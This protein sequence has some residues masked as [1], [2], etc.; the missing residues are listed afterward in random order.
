MKSTQDLY[1]IVAVCM[2]HGT[3]HSTIVQKKF[4]MQFL[5]SHVSIKACH[6]SHASMQLY[7][8]KAKQYDY[9][10]EQPPANS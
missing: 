10:E 5:N 3:M 8:L 7:L 2:E 4:C 6:G 1:A 9:H